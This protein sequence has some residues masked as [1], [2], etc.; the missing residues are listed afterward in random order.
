MTDVKKNQ[1]AGQS[2]VS[3]ADLDRLYA[4]ATPGQKVTVGVHRHQQ[5]GA[6]TITR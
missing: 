3:L 1:F 2:V 4:A 5:D 6:L